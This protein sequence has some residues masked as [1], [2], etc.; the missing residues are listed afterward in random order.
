MF[1]LFAAYRP[2]TGL[3][4]LFD[5]VDLTTVTPRQIYYAVHG[6]PPER[7][8]Y[9][10]P[11]PDFEPRRR[12]V[13]ALDS[14]EFRSS[15]I[16]NLLKA[17]PERKRLLLLH[18]PRAAGSELSAR[19][20]SRYPSLSRQLTWTDWL[21]PQ[22]FYLAIRQFVAE[23][24]TSD[25]IFVRG[26]NTLEDYRQWRAIRF[27]DSVF[28]ILRQP[29]D[30]IIS[31]VNYA[32]TRMF[33]KALPVRPD[34]V[35]WRRRFEVADAMVQ[36]SKIEAASL[37][38]R[39]LRDGGVVAP[40]TA[41]HYLGDGTAAHAVENIVIH[42]IELTDFDHYDAWCRQR[43]GIDSRSRSNLSTGYV[44]LDDFAGDD[45]DY[46]ALITAQDVQLYGLAQQAFT[47]RGGTSIIGG[48]IL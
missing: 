3:D 2:E 33:A 30:M 19:L 14:R 8:E 38:R 16:K 28:A 9:A 32:L 11:P 44:T 15:V 25:S 20:M 4:G 40:N 10:I 6:R 45:R 41:C 13:A 35:A 48:E 18:I 27:Q 21:T 39:I 47:K 17:F 43:W 23:A 7:I 36:P 31:Q 24:D 34:T 5:G 22:E 37:A 46:M 42:A 1:E 26:H 12:F 29:L